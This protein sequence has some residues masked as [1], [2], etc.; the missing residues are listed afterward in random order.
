M[1]HGKN[2]LDNFIKERVDVDEA[3]KT[4]TWA[5]GSSAAPVGSGA[6]SVFLVGPR[7]SGRMAL[8]QALARQLKL[9]LTATERSS[10]LPEAD[11]RPAVHVV[12]PEVF[13]QSAGVLKARGVVAYLMAPPGLL[14]ERL[15]VTDED[16]RRRMAEESAMDEPVYLSN[17]HFVLPSGESLAE[18]LKDLAEKLALTGFACGGGSR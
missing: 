8:G 15:G 6:R 12:A 14:M 13:R 18:N 4:R 16:E 2:T 10:D 11:D 5:R 9:P 7:G 17:A 1:S 3:D